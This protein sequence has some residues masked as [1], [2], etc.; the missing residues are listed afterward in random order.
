[1]TAFLSSAHQI[2]FVTTYPPRECGI[3]TFSADLTHHLNKLFIAGEETPII[4]MNTESLPVY[5]YP[6]EVRYQIIQEHPLDYQKAARLINDDP[7]L[8]VVSIQHEFGIFG[9]DYGSNLL[10]FLKELKKPAVITFH[11]VLPHPTS[12]MKRVMKNILQH[13]ALSIVMTKSSQE[14]LEKIY[15][16][17]SKKIR[18][19]PHGI[20]DV[21]YTDGMAAKIRIGL[22]GK[23]IISTFGLLGRGKGIEYGIRALPEICR[24]YPETRYLI[25]GSTHPMVVRHEGEKYRN[26]LIKLTKELGVRDKVIFYNTYVSTSELLNFLQATDLYFSCSQNPD[27]AVS[28]TLSY[29][30]GAGRPV[31]STAFRQAKEIVTPDV[32]ALVPFG[33][34]AEITK[35]TI[36]LFSDEAR[37]ITLAKNAYVKTRS[38]T[39]HNIALSYLKE[40][41]MLAPELLSK[42]KKLPALV[43]KHLRHLTSAHGIFQF[44]H[45]NDPD[46]AW[47]YTLDDNARALLVVSQQHARKKTHE[48]ERLARIYLSFIEH[49]AQ[50]EGGFINYIHHDKKPHATR[51]KEENLDDAHG[52]A[53]WALAV[54]MKSKFPATLRNRARNLFLASYRIGDALTSPRA[55]AYLIKALVLFS[56]DKKIKRLL[57]QKAEW[58]VALYE[59]N[60]T[61]SWPWFEKT[62]TYSNAALPEALFLA[63]AATGRKKYVETARSALDF[64]ISHSFEGVVCVPV[65]QRGWFPR[66]GKKARYDQQ[67]EEVSAL[68]LALRTAY[69]ITHEEMYAIRMRHAFDWFMGN[70]IQRQVVCSVATGGC[71]DGLGEEGVNIN[72]GAESTVSYLLARMAVEAGV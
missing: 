40:F 63:Y 10:F 60:F 4:A 66:D 3:A 18:V 16:V 30:L 65:G 57:L 41:E 17:P 33:N 11:T 42:Q 12:G 39:W 51:N 43:F 19:I 22:S 24:A 49:V 54:M 70:N 21:P 31:I 7:R 37:R 69:A 15:H 56:D 5:R 29:A 44:A 38:L 26:E 6:K 58:L 71:F 55:V 68:V 2:V 72:Q 53:L 67:P 20:H 61:A 1:M 50:E 14:L 64:L 59:K 8:R 46:P 27:Q 25:I 34:S 23:K 13:T 36:S 48:T 28:G 35:K 47:G 45:F 52:R 62:L 32:G 9:E